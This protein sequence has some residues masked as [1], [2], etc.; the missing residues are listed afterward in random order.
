MKW[1]HLPING[2]ICFKTE[3]FIENKYLQGIWQVS[4]LYI[5]H[6]HHKLFI[7]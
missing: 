1:K 3:A 7:A 5:P 6:L 2:G 4:P